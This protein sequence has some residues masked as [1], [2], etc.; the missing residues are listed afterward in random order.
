LTTPGAAA[1]VAATVEVA[2]V[3]VFAAVPTTVAAAAVAVSMTV[4]VLL[5]GGEGGGGGVL[6][7][8]GTDADPLDE[9][10]DPDPLDEVGRAL[11]SARSG[12]DEPCSAATVVVAVPIGLAVVDAST[13]PPG[14]LPPPA[15]RGC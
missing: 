14:T 1:T 12:A 6:P 15:L 2:V 13:L 10:G 3:T 7:V 8:S 11:G 9:V 5:G 4:G